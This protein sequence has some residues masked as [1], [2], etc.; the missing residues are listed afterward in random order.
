MKKFRSI[1]IFCQDVSFVLRKLLRSFA[2]YIYIFLLTVSSGQAMASAVNSAEANVLTFPAGSSSQG[3]VIS[4]TSDSKTLTTG[5]KNATY[6]ATH[7][8]VVPVSPGTFSVGFGSY[9]P[10]SYSGPGTTYLHRVQITNQNGVSILDETFDGW[11]QSSTATTGNITRSEYVTTGAINW[12]TYADTTDFYTGGGSAFEAVD[13]AGDKGMVYP[14]DGGGPFSVLIR[15]VIDVPNGTTELRI[16]V[17]W[18]YSVSIF[19]GANRQFSIGL[20]RGTIAPEFLFSFSNTVKSTPEDTVMTFGNSDFSDNSNNVYNSIRLTALPDAVIGKLLLDGTAVA[21]GDVINSADYTK[22]TLAPMKDASGETSFAYEPYYSGAYQ[23]AITA[24][25]TIVSVNDSPE[26]TINTG[27]VVVEGKTIQITNTMLA[28]TDSDD[29][30]DQLTYVL[31]GLPAAGS[32]YIDRNNNQVLDTDEQ[33]GLGQQFTQADIDAS[34]IYYKH[35]KGSV[36]PDV[37]AFTLQDGGEDSAT[38]VNGNF[39][40]TVNPDTHNVSLT[41]NNGAEPETKAITHGSSA[42]FTLNLNNKHPK[43]SSNCNAVLNGNTLTTAAITASC[44]I[45][46]QLFDKVVVAA[47]NSSSAVVNE[48]RTLA[49]SGGAGDKTLQQASVIRAGQSSVLDQQNSN[50]VLVKQTDGSYK[51]SASRTGRYQFDFTDA[52]SGE[53][54]SVSFDVKPYVAFTSSKQPGQVGLETTLSI[55]LS[56]EAIDYPVTVKFQGTGLPTD[57]TELTI[58]Q[59]DNR[60]KDYRLTPVQ[61]DKVQLTLLRDDL[62]N[63]VL[64]TPANHEIVLQTAKVPLAL[65]VEVQQNNVA[66]NVVKNID[67]LVRLTA[68][69]RDSQQTTY[70]FENSQLGLS[71]NGAVAEFNPLTIAAGTYDVLV[72]ATDVNGRTGQ[73]TAQ[74]R[75]IESCPIGDCSNIGSSGIPASVNA[76]NSFKERLPLCPQQ[77]DNNRVS[78][79]TADSSGF[80]EAPAGY[81]LSLGAVSGQQS[82]SSGQFGVALNAN[83][84]LDAGYSQ[85]GFKV[86]F[87]ITELDNPGEA[88]PVMIPLPT[89]TS[90]PENAIWRKLIQQKWQNFVVDAANK[91]DSAKRESS[92]LCPSVA[93]DT[94]QSG[95][96]AGNE[97]IRLTIADGGP[98]DDDG[99]TNSVVRDPGVLATIQSYQL[100]FDTAGSDAIATKTIT[101]GQSVTAPSAPTKLGYTFAGWSPALPATMPANNVSVTAQWTINQYTVNFESN[102]GSAVAATTYN[103]A[104][105]VT[106][107]AAPTRTGYT[108]AGWSPALPATMPAAN[109]SV[110]AQWTINQYTVSF[111]SNGGSAVS[112]ISYNYAAPVSAPAVPTRDGYTFDGWSPALPATMP[113]QDVKVTAK[114]RISSYQGETK[115]GS[116][117]WLG[118]A[119]L[120]LLALRR[121]SR[122][123]LA[124]LPLSLSAQATDWYGS[125]ELGHANTSVDAAKLQRQLADAGITAKT[126]VEQQSR[127][128]HRLALGYQLNQWLAVEAGWVSLGNIY[129]RFDEVSAN[130]SPA[131][132]YDAMP[133]SG[134]GAEL[135]LVTGWDL[136]NGWRPT[137]RLGAWHNQSDYRLQ[138]PESAM[139]DQQNS[140]LLV[141]GAGL[142]YQM[143]ERWTVKLQVSQYNTDHYRT[144]LW[145]AGAEFR[146]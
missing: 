77:T 138:S 142:G 39:N 143:S 38:S 36:T 82:W 52:S 80:I 74:V 26:L 11:S 22:L 84:V 62:Q 16:N 58:L 111:D 92:G 55:F 101:F 75:I 35:I 47:Q 136:N 50:A 134:D 53:Q 107:P 93:A 85:V 115:G 3:S 32:L 67:G 123:A 114:W 113:A 78:T 91:I 43:V 17:D 130:G 116:I 30:A 28:G 64:G 109:V 121:Q 5:W 65:F 4:M 8:M 128:G 15:T 29:S 87:D 71:V 126:A 81:Q 46:V 70:S 54:V 57:L 120:A 31:N 41:L 23:T 88:V 103:F 59:D 144:R 69:Q 97:C 83:S 139:K 99:L 127:A 117:G 45:N 106:A 105:P 102:G 119:G 56:D 118:L 48:S 24:N 141:I 20:K 89:G 42:S 94:W 122:W 13:S 112:G 125:V 124:L 33:L 34:K 90:I 63:A 6:D 72:K 12:Q 66:T 140:T 18:R 73:Y 76:Q 96:I 27:L 146:F 25:L 100:S 108:F 51:F 110:T 1:A 60:R 61:A 44:Q 137:L 7:G 132:L 2:W 37:F 133:Q 135:S 10:E 95:L 19:S 86:N 129:S 79:C 49:L 68:S 145:S 40:I 9:V 131:S 98:N 21:I 104:A 14:M